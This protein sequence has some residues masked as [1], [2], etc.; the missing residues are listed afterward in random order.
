MAD[1]WICVDCRSTNSAKDEA[2]L[3]LPA[4]RRTTAS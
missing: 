4:C 2:L 1:M 3:P